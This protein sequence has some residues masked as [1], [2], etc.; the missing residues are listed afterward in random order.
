MSKLYSRQADRR[1]HAAMMIG[2]REARDA[3]QKSANAI[4]HRLKPGK[5]PTMSRR[6]PGAL[7]AQKIN[8]DPG[9][10]K[11]KARNTVPGLG[12]HD[13]SG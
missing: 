3:V 13:E 11:A 10:I 12:L 6:C 7:M 4:T 5:P 1:E 2:T 9:T 8:N